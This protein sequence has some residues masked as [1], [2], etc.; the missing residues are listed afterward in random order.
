VEDYS[1]DLAR[2][3][4]VGQKGKDNGVLLLIAY[5][6]HKLRIEVGRGLEGTL[7]D[8]QSGRIIRE[9]LTP[10]LRAGDVGGAIEA[11]TTAI[12]AA[13]GDVDANGQAPAVAQPQPYVTPVSRRPSVAP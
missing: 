5:D 4:G 1:I 10:R 3:W 11:G 8:L 2:S 7:T 9:E 13:L 6:D 12:R